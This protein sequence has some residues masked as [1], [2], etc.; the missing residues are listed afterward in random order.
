MIELCSIMRITEKDN[1][2][3]IIFDDCSIIILKSY[4]I[5]FLTEL[6]NYVNKWSKK[7][8]LNK[9]SGLKAF[10]YLTIKDISG[11]DD[12]LNFGIKKISI[13]KL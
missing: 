4:A 9:D 11:R 13:N 3:K 5:Q 12:L 2:A 7:Y 6:K 8:E 10:V 1:Y